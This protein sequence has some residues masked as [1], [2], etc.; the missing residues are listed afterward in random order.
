MNATFRAVLLL[1]DKKGVLFSGRHMMI[2][3]G[4]NSVDGFALP[5]NDALKITTVNKVRVSNVQG[6]KSGS[7]TVLQTILIHKTE[8]SSHRDCEKNIIIPAQRVLEGLKEDDRTVLKVVKIEDFSSNGEAV[9]EPYKI[10]KS[11]LSRTKI[12]VYSAMEDFQEQMD[13]NAKRGGGGR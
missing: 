1:V 11:D 5:N 2:A 6:A 13:K 8:F 7:N 4:A 9:L 3:S 12:R 10:G